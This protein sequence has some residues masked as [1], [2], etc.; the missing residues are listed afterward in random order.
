M[1]FFS[2][3]L[4]CAGAGF[5]SCIL[6]VSISA[7]TGGRTAL[8]EDEAKPEWKEAEVLPP[9]WPTDGNLIPLYVSSGTSAQFFVDGRSLTLGN[10]GVVRFTVVIRAGGGAENVSYEGIRCETAERKLYAIG[11]GRGEWVSPRN[12][13]WQR[14]SDNT[15]NRHHAVLFKEF[16]CLPGSALPTR[17]EILRSLR[18]AASLR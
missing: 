16:F 14:I 15:L 17:D 12:S 4:R 6:A 13:A 8:F 1:L 2:R 18:G 9:S 10:D 5:L 11:R 7:C 3:S